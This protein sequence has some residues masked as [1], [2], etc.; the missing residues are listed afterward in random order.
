M[1]VN[2]LLNI[3]IQS[4]VLFAVIFCVIRFFPIISPRVQTWL[5]TFFFA[6]LAIAPF[7]SFPFYLTKPATKWEPVEG[8]LTST[9]SAELPV[10]G[11]VDSYLLPWPL[12]LWAIGFGIVSIVGLL[13][14]RS[15]VRQVLACPEAPDNLYAETHEIAVELGVKQTIQVRLKDS[16]PCSI[17]V[18]GATILLPSSL[19]SEEE[20]ESRRAILIHEVAHI[21]HRDS[22]WSLAFAI[23]RAVYFFNPFAWLA[24]KEW[25]TTRELMCDRAVISHHSISPRRYAEVLLSVCI[26]ANPNPAATRSLSSDFHQL[27]RRI[28]HMNKKTTNKGAASLAAITALLVIGA[29]STPVHL[30]WKNDMT[31]TEQTALPRLD[32]TKILD[33]SNLLAP[34]NKLDTELVEIELNGAAFS[35][36]MRVLAKEIKMAIDVDSLKDPK[37][38]ISK[39]KITARAALD[40]LCE[41]ANMKWKQV[42]DNNITISDK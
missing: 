33:S 40:A 12:I 34:L 39:R 14:Y 24:Y 5:W 2:P 9:T 6:H 42:D 23:I 18:D 10:Q 36:V 41:K 38:S 32:D 4:S 22:R 3:L 29:L 17:G 20:Q 1:I 35:S 26:Q 15:T 13:Q 19:L 11:S 25:G 7:F 28:K 21:K 31:S 37:V 27:Q 8:L 30:A 16:M